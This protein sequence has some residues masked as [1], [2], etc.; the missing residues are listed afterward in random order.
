PA[1]LRPTQ[2]PFQRRPRLFLGRRVGRAVIKRHGDVAAQRQLNLHRQLRRQQMRAAV[3]MRAEPYPFFGDAAE[4]FFLVLARPQAEDLVA[5]AVGEDGMGPGG[6]LVQSAQAADALVTGAQIQMV[7][8]AEDDLRPQ[9]FQIILADGLDRGPRAHRHEAGRG[10]VAMDG[11][12]DAAPRRPGLGQQFK[13]EARHQAKAAA[14]PEITS[15]YSSHSDPTTASVD[16]NLPFLPPSL[17]KPSASNITIQME[18]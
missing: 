7:G 18:K 6:E 5:T 2:R 16:P 17:L 14:T 1:P 15:T 4:G 11:V 8:V 3:E 10:D 12:Q 13:R 9:S